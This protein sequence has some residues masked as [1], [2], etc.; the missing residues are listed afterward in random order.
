MLRDCPSIRTAVMVFW[1]GKGMTELRNL[2][3]LIIYANSILR[4]GSVTISLITRLSQGTLL[5]LDL[6]G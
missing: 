6:A 5:V 4:V 3:V 2:T 1:Y